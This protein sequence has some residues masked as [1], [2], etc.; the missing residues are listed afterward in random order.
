MRRCTERFSVQDCVIDPADDRLFIRIHNVT[1]AF[2][3]APG[4]AVRSLLPG[5][6]L[7]TLYPGEDAALTS[8]SD[9]EAFDL[10]DES[11]DTLQQTPFWRV[12]EIFRDQC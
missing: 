11:T 3:I 10:R 2:C 9:L 6:R 4:I 8:F 5:D 12:F 7:A 1:A